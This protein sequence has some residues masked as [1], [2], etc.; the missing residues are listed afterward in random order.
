M[1]PADAVLPWAGCAPWACADEYF[2]FSS[3][4]LDGEKSL[5]KETLEGKKIRGLKVTRRL[6]RGGKLCPKRAPAF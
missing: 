2:R 4:L 6:F 5:F 3:Y 1:I